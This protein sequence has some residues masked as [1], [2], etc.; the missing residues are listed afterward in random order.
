MTHPS[1]RSARP[2]AAPGRFLKNHFVQLLCITTLGLPLSNGPAAQSAPAS[3]TSHSS[4]PTAQEQ[5][6][7]GTGD[8]R[9]LWIEDWA[10][11]SDGADLGNTHGGMLVDSKGRILV[12][13]D[14]TD[15]V[16]IF[17]SDGTFVE[18]WGKEF[19]GGLHG[20][21]LRTEDGKELLYLAHTARHE[22]VKTTMAGEVLWTIGWPEGAGIYASEAEYKPTAV[23]V[24]DN[25]RI[26][27]ADGYGKSWIHVYDADR[28]YVKSFGG[29]GE[30][31]GKFR[32]PHG[33]TIDRRGE[34]PLLLACDRENHRLQWFTL[35]GKFV[36]AVEKG[37]KRPCNAWPLADKTLAVAD[38]GGRV[39]ILDVDGKVIVQLGDRANAKLQATN[40]VPRKEWQPG[41]FFAPHGI[42]ADAAGNLFVMDWNTSGR[43]TKLQRRESSRTAS[44]PAGESGGER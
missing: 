43:I 9:Y 14:T 24:A 30:E 22:I 5:V 18:S 39:T 38:L 7:V 40:R 4:K 10:K 1:P 29:L 34:E 19:Q 23:A 26:F 25:G 12:N 6:E 11:R 31:Q 42:C 27:V 21:C 28:R 16:M 20:M 41:L 8:H 15:A 37:L 3:Q 32:T 17:A 44:K 13:T 33:L 36:R 2:P 35:E